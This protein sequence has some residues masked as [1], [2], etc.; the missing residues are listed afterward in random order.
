MAID[1][2]RAYPAPRS[3][4]TCAA[5]A[6]AASRIALATEVTRAPTVVAVDLAP[7]AVALTR[8]K[9]GPSTGRRT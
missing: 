2:A 4:W 5:G 6:G 1:G 3:S 7:E 8:K 9:R